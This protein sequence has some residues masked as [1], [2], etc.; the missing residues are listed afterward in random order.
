MANVHDR[1]RFMSLKIIASPLPF[2]FR[3]EI[4][5]ETWSVVPV[6]WGGKGLWEEYDRPVYLYQGGSPLIKDADVAVLIYSGDRWFGV[7]Q[8]RGEYLFTQAYQDVFKALVTN[9]HGK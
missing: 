8:P 2:S 9:Y 4:Y 1:P 3:L 7:Y 5:N 6:D